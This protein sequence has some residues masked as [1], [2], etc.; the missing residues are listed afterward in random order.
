MKNDGLNQGPTALLTDRLVEARW[1]C[2]WEGEEAMWAFR[3][4]RLLSL[5]RSVLKL[6][7][8]VG[9]KNQGGSCKRIVGFIDG[10]GSFHNRLQRLRRSQAEA[11]RRAYL[12]DGDELAC[13]RLREGVRGFYLEG[14][15]EENLLLH[16]MESKGRLSDLAIPSHVGSLQPIANID[17]R[18]SRSRQLAVSSTGQG[19]RRSRSP[20]PML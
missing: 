12:R 18:T 5:L 14:G 15:D 1:A 17:C 10:S 7:I 19:L 16:I 6:G 11:W 3:K 13:P 9:P 2:E 8:R 4:A 20:V